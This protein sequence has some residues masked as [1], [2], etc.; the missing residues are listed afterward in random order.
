MKKVLLS[1]G[2]TGGHIYPALSIAKAVRRQ[3]PQAEIGYIGTKNGLEARI[4]PKEGN[5][6]FFD[7]EIQGFRRKLSLDN[8]QTV[9]KFLRA[10]RDCK[11]Y[12]RD[13]QPDVVVGTGGYVS[14]PSLYAA[15]RMGVPT[16]ILEPDVLPGLTTRF[17]SRYV[18]TVAVS[19]SG[20]EKHL[21]KA[22]RIIH[23][24]N[25]RGTEVVRANAE[26]GRESLGI[27]DADKPVILIFGGSR[28]A[29]PLNDAVTEM[30]P[31]IREAR[32][33]HFVYVT[34]EVHYETVTA[35]IKDD[36]T[37]L[38]VRPYIYNMPDV[39]AG[40]SLVVGRAG[41]STLA[42]LT[43]LGVPSIMIPSPY[44]TNN[45]QEANARWLEEQGA[46]R[47]I[48]ERELSGERLWETIREIAEDADRRR[49]MSETARQLGRPDAAGE[50]VEELERLAGKVS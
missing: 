27:H 30:M 23:T 31:K 16:L 21:T 13:F 17:L 22:E 5:I 2:G 37:N 6:Q 14:G 25:P 32:H 44:V 26:A 10:V 38:T 9:A 39:L 34:G 7:V 24:G 49:Q 46:G 8:L 29:K 3:N 42:E 45:H 48:L 11:Q 1:G 19:L 12:I 43:A 28:G 35:N 20:S 36:I 40:T 15:A 33:L 18:D 47:M 41:A 50:I 4:V